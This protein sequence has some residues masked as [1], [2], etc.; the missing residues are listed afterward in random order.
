MTGY[1]V[2]SPFHDLTTGDMVGLGQRVPSHVVEDADRLQRLIEANCI[3]PE[4]V[5]GD[6]PSLAGLAPTA[7]KP[8]RGRRRAKG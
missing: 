4:P 3:E 8:T 5:S 2:V 1:R 6:T 7:A